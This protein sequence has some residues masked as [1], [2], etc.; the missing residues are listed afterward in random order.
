MGFPYTWESL[1]KHVLIEKYIS[2][3]SIVDWIWLINKHN[4]IASSQW[5]ALAQAFPILGNYLAWRVGNGSQV[6]IRSNVIIRCDG[7]IVLVENRIQTLKTNGLCT[8][9][10]LADW[11]A[12]TIWNQAWHSSTE[13]ELDVQWERDWHNYISSLHQSH[14]QLTENL[15]E[16]AWAYPHSGG[17][18]SA[19]LG[20]CSLRNCEEENIVWWHKL[21]WKI[22]GPR[23]LPSSFGS[24]LKV[25]F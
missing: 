16:L 22:K 5:M 6:R 9:N 2:P 14:I 15:D 4:P 10:Q 21:I 19:K 3:L 20:Y 1:E 13:L 8:L 7:R 25:V 11:E 12:T 17:S 18:H 24:C 23:R